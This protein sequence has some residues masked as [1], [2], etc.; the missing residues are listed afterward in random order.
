LQSGLRRSPDEVPIAPRS[1]WNSNRCFSS[2]ALTCD[3]DSGV[4][5]IRA[6]KRPL[7]KSGLVLHSIKFCRGLHHTEPALASTPIGHDPTP[8]KP[9]ITIVQIES[10]ERRRSGELKAFSHPRRRSEFSRQVWAAAKPRP[11]I[12][13]IAER[14]KAMTTTGHERCC[15]LSC[16][17][18]PRQKIIHR[19]RPRGPFEQCNANKS[20]PAVA[21]R[22]RPSKR[23]QPAI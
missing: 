7:E 13:F 22:S 6:R 4:Q 19:G 14:D 20:E 18:Q 10:S 17:W 9:R 1:T 11:S 5:F 21:A 16:L 23:A 3:S 15:G 12:Y 8:P 2:Q